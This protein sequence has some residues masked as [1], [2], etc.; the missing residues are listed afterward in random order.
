L[1]ALEFLNLILP[2]N[3]YL[4]GIAKKGDQKPVQRVFTETE[5]LLGFLRKFNAEGWDVYHAI[6]SFGTRRGIQDDRGEYHPRGQNNVHGVA[7]LCGDVDTQE[8]HSLAKYATRI[9]AYHAV[10]DFCRAARIPLP[11]F[12]SS[13]GGL[14]FYWPLDEVLGPAEWKR[15]ATSLKL[16][17]IH[18]KLAADHRL[19]ANSSAVLRTPGFLH[20]RLQRVVEVGNP[21]EPFS[22][23][24]FAHLLTEFPPDVRSTPEI[25]ALDHRNHES[26]IIGKLSRANWADLSDPTHLA[27]NCRQIGSVCDRPDLADEPMH[28]LVAGAFKNC[29]PAGEE[30]YLAKLAAEWRDTGRAKLDRWLTG[31]P[32]CSSFHSLK[33]DGCA[34]CRF[35]DPAQKGLDRFRFTSPIHAGRQ[36]IRRPSCED[37]AQNAEA[38]TPNQLVAPAPAENAQVNG[39]HVNGVS[40]PLAPFLKG[41]PLPIPFDWGKIYK[42]ALVVKTEDA[43]GEPVEILVS[44]QP[45]HLFGIHE[46]EAGAAAGRTYAFRQ[47]SPYKGWQVITM[48]A[49]DF[50]TAGGMVNIHNAGANITNPARFKEFVTKSVD[51]LTKQQPPTPRYEQCGWKKDEHGRRKSFLIGRTMIEHGAVKEVAVNDELHTR[52]QW[53]GPLRGA[54]I[55]RWR[56]IVLELLP[57]YDEAGWFTVLCS[58]GSVFVSWLMGYESAGVTNNREL[59][60]G[61]GKTTRLRAAAS[62]WGRWDGLVITNYDTGPSQ[63]WTRAALCHLPVIHDELALHAS[64]KDPAMIVDYL[65]LCTEGRDKRRMEMGGKGIRYTQGN[66]SN[67]CLSASNHSIHDQVRVHGRN[68]DAP[69]MRCLEINSKVTSHLSP[70]AARELEEEMWK[71]SGIVGF[72]FIKGTLE[73]QEF[74]AEKLREWQTWIYANTNLRQKHRY[75]VT[76]IVTAAVAGEMCDKLGKILPIDFRKIIMWVLND[77]GALTGKERDDDI[78]HGTNGEIAM[79][80]FLAEYAQNYCQV[81]GP[82]Q[83]GLPPIKP[84]KEPKGAFLMRYEEGNKRLYVSLSAFRAYCAVKG[85]S[86]TDCVKQL[87][88]SKFAVHKDKQMALGA[89]TTLPSLRQRC[90]ELDMAHPIA[91]QMPRLVE[92]TGND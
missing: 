91:M 30:F 78:V 23:S 84:I 14:H 37:T 49:G 87:V 19:T 85:F 26:T 48:P 20:Q 50:H 29:G 64:R 47:W 51:M 31:P 39:Y 53:L 6:A 45:I 54:D 36:A 67:N 58:L 10:C 60:S 90:I 9:E 44:E 40:N 35:F 65:H 34:G 27:A 8:S 22:V 70:K 74:A 32:Y 21:L 52:A 28:R 86:F 57:E 66:W 17:C 41:I 42:D 79:G 33:P 3:G 68:S 63:G 46:S 83:P 7:T 5:K 16:A 1:D 75:W 88:D 43:D 12:V 56:E 89:G 62:V 2:E 61:T 81:P 25:S 71:H 59:N 69:I 38:Q 73:H 92:A 13:G 72:T 15:L 18:F 82:F 77:I 76:Q 24:Q 80:D 55:R 11:I 4:I